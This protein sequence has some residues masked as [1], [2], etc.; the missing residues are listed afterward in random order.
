M[1]EIFIVE[2]RKAGSQDKN[3]WIPVLFD[4]YIDEGEANVEAAIVREFQTSSEFR[5]Q[6]YIR[7]EK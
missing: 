4:F 6:K 3:D 1:S 7:E 5:T 2:Q